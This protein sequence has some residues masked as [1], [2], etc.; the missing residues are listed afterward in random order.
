[1]LNT[2]ILLLSP[3]HPLTSVYTYMSAKLSLLIGDPDSMKIL[4]M[5]IQSIAVSHG[6]FSALFVE[7]RDRQREEL[8]DLQRHLVGLS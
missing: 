7:A 5:A 6:T 8:G 3:Y 1:M 2:F 4:E